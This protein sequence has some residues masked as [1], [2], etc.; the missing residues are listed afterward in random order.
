M[1][2]LPSYTNPGN[3]EPAFSS[4]GSSATGD[5]FTHSQTMHIIVTRENVYDSTLSTISHTP[6]VIENRLRIN[7]YASVHRD[8]DFSAT[9]GGSTRISQEFTVSGPITG[10]IED[11]GD[12]YTTQAGFI[13]RLARVNN[14][15]GAIID[16]LG[17]CSRSGVFY[18]DN[19]PGFWD[20]STY[21]TLSNDI[22]SEAARL[23]HQQCDL[24][25]IT[26]INV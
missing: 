9:F 12:I 19:R 21:A 22:I 2:Q 7:W 11:G 8:V 26:L 23:C 4:T 20:G 18:I 13:R 3:I 10:N 14:R 17:D 5:W 15:T 24:F 25:K 16:D 1:P 6:D